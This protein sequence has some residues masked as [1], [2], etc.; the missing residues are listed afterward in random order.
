VWLRTLNFCVAQCRVAM[1]NKY[2]CVGV[3]TKIW[4]CAVQSGNVRNIL[5]HECAHL[6]LALCDTKW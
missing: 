3:Q 2:W 1:R 6:N 5:A 4:H